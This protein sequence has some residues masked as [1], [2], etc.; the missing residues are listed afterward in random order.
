MTPKTLHLG[1][2][3]EFFDMFLNEIKQEEYRKLSIYYISKLFNYKDVPPIKITDRS[4]KV[5]REMFLKRLLSS[6]ESRKDCFEYL[7][8]YDTITFSNGYKQV[9][10]LP[11]FVI[12]FKGVEIRT[13]NTDWG[14]VEG[15]EYFVIKTG[16]IL[17]KSNC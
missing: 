9:E 7:K 16:K 12:E 5:T 11:R 2:T 10:K 17:S 3:K 8:E 6:E 13:G 1:L 14:A 4:H 15:I